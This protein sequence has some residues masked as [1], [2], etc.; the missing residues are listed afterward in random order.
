M[1]DDDL[2]RYRPLRHLTDAG[3]GGMFPGVWEVIN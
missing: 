1:A 3:A 2:S